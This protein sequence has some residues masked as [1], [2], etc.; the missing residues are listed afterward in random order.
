MHAAIS[1]SA[2][3]M[4]DCDRMRW[5]PIPAGAPSGVYVIAADGGAPTPVMRTEPRY[6][7]DR[8]VWSPDGT[9]IAASRFCTRSCGL[10]QVL[11]AR[12]DGTQQFIMVENKRLGFPVSIV[13]WL[14]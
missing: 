5:R 14:R 9:Y 13:S 8:F 12:T 6:R 11:G 10:A 2:Y 3:D 1:A 7:F 4:V